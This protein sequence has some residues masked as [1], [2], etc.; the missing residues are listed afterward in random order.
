MIEKFLVMGDGTRLPGCSAGYYDRMLWLYF[1]DM[2]M[3]EVVGIVFDPPKLTT[4]DFVIG[5]QMIRYTNFTEVINIVKG[6][7]EVKVRLIGENSSHSEMEDSI[8]DP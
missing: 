2:T 7:G 8:Y 6:E 1:K 3:L 4:I 5:D